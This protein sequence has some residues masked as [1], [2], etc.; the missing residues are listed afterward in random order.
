MKGR[1]GGWVAAIAA[2]VVTAAGC[3]HG[4]GSGAAGGVRVVA[5]EQ[6][7]AGCEKV[8]EVRV[9]GTWTK[10]AAREELRSLA[11]AKGANALVV[12]NGSGTSGLAYRCSGGAAASQK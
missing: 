1:M 12:S 10:G 11:Q 2:A 3:A 4:N 6:E 8:A 9:S 7:V 5:S